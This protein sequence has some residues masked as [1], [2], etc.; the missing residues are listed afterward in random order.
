M[1]HGTIS[2]AKSGCHCLECRGAMSI[3]SRGRA[4]GLRRAALLRHHG[5]TLTQVNDDPVEWARKLGI[6]FRGDVA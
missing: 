3:Y 6:E 4:K 2:A 1:N 5:V